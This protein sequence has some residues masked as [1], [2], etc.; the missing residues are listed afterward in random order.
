MRRLEP[1]VFYLHKLGNPFIIYHF[2]IF[3]LQFYIILISL[4]TF[5][6]LLP[7]NNIIDIKS[8]RNAMFACSNYYSEKPEA[9][10]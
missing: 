5:V 7:C 10:E 8:S 4:T 1:Y 9:L 6:F 2:L 3:F